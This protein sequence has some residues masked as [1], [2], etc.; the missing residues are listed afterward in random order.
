MTNDEQLHP[1]I[2]NALNLD[3]N[4]RKVRQYYEDWATSYDQDLAHEAY[5]APEITAVLLNK[6]I[7]KHNLLPAALEVADVGCGTGLVG[8]L[9]AQAGFKLI[10]GM[11]I[12]PLM[13]EIAQQ[14]GVYRQLQGDVDMTQSLNPAWRNAYDVVLC[15]GMFTL[16][17]VPPETLRPLFDMTRSQGFIIVST[18]TGYY[19]DSNYQAISDQ[20]IADGIVMLEQML[21]NAPYTND[22]LSHYWVY[23]KC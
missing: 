17:H 3:G 12:S 2:H 6:T 5:T 22:S 23:Q 16:G 14:R 10:D 20:F 11:D 1:A 21:P 7:D 18:R 13:V 15:C 4:P 8:V 9:L 19:D